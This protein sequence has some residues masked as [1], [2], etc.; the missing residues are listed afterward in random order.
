MHGLQIFD[1]L[2]ESFNNDKIR[3]H[4][5]IDRLM[6]LVFRIPSIRL[7]HNYMHRTLNREGRIYWGCIHN[8]KKCKRE[9]GERWERG[10]TEAKKG[11]PIVSKVQISPFAAINLRS[12][13]TSSY[14]RHE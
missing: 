12:L 4:S 7:M 11:L 9:E 5:T 3:L 10:M 14:G 13:V 8:D 1:R 6:P 2:R